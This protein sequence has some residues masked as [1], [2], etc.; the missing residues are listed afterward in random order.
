[1]AS[2]CVLDDGLDAVAVAGDE[3]AEIDGCRVYF[4]FLENTERLTNDGTI[5]VLRA[6]VADITGSAAVLLRVQ[7]RRQVPLAISTAA[8]RSA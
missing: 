5:G 8:Q 2:R 1:M 3:F 4:V 7:L 6:R